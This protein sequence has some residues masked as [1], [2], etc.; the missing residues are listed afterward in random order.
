MVRVEV[1]ARPM[2]LQE[3]VDLGLEGA[4][5]IPVKIQV[6]LERKASAFIGEHLNLTVDGEA[7]KPQFDRINF[8]CRNL[9]TS[10]VV[11]PR[12][13]LDAHS[14]TLGAICVLPVAGLPVMR[15]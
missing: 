8:L 9:R 4:E 12:E 13:E 1:I 3:C 11:N 5:T 10:T 14:A 6:D 7:A 15:S 2:D